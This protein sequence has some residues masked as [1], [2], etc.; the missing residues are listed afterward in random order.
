MKKI[1]L[2]SNYADLLKLML[3]TG[4]RDVYKFNPNKEL[5]Y[6]REIM[7]VGNGESLNDDKFLWT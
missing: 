6:P 1:F 4:Y 5:I 7:L 3:Q 2:I